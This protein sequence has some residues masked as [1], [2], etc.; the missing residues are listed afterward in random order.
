LAG[1]DTCLEAGRNCA[2][3]QEV[4][5]E[6]LVQRL[7]KGLDIEKFLPFTSALTEIV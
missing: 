6:G 4:Q 5:K 2:G 1:F 3:E 7:K